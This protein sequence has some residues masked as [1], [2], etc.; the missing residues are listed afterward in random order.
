VRSESDGTSR[1]PPGSPRTR[2][3][4]RRT[5]SLAPR[6]IPCPKRSRTVASVAAAS[7]A[8]RAE[9][10]STST[11]PSVVG[12]RAAASARR[13]AASRAAGGAAASWRST[14]AKKPRSPLATL[15][16]AVGL[17]S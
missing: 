10:P 16:A 5:R 6:A 17:K 9:S 11:A 1:S 15:S 4:G 13:T 2:T 12:T 8:R 7:M 14:S 3:A